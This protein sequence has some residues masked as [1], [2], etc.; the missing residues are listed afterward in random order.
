M[1]KRCAAVSELLDKM[2]RVREEDEVA[3]F[4]E[5]VP[6]AS[7]LGLEMEL[8]EERVRGR[9]R[10]ADHLIGNTFVSALHGGTTGALLETTALLEVV[11][12]VELVRLPKII[13]LTVEYLRKGKA[14]DTFA[15]AT[16]TR[17]GGRVANLRV[18]AWQSEPNS[19]IAAA[20]ALVLLARP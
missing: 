5:A 9:L 11:R 3:Q 8:V 2:R 18:T 17:L 15:E 6:Y 20:N 10:F 19:P 4:L 16:I 13:S 7:F 12:H 14:E 1:G